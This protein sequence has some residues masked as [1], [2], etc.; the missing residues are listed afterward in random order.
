MES[1]EQDRAPQPQRAAAGAW[2]FLKE[3]LIVVVGALIAST[4]LRLFLLQV[5]LIPSRSMETTLDVGDRVAVLKLGG[6]ERGDVVVFRDDLE[7]LGNPDRYT[8]QWWQEALTFVGLVPDEATNHLVKRVIGLAGDHVVCCDTG[9]RITV[10]GA[11]L[12]ET[13]YLY[14]DP[15]GVQDGASTYPFD[16]VVPVGRVF[17]LGD[18]RTNSAD[19]RCHLDEAVGGIAG[20]GAFP[21]T[22][23]VVGRA[24]AT[25]FP[26][27]RWRGFATPA[28]FAAI[29]DAPQPAPL[30]PT[31]TGELPPC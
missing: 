28:T 23:S 13:S 20:L 12:D 5:F 2:S 11:A 14:T 18:H 25:I 19:S 15:S 3:V 21:L 7:W 10:N 22:E 29:G 24:T 30:E 1:D 27:D 16:V 9:G 17:V 8:R 31:V 4:V 6:F 26:F